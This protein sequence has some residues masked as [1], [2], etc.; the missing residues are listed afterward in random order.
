M[1]KE[2][3]SKKGKEKRKLTV[4]I[5]PKFRNRYS[6]PENGCAFWTIN[7]SEDFYQLESMMEMSKNNR[8]RSS[9]S[10]GRCLD[11]SPGGGLFVDISW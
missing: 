7:N 2:K 5:F 8:T 3:E 11:T 1:T 10:A 6:W 4:V 9:Q